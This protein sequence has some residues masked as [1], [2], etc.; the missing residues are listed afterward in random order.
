MKLR[1]IQGDYN[2]GLDLGTGSVGWAVTSIYGELLYFKSKPTWGSRIFPSA[3]TAAG[4]RSKRGQRRRYIRRRWRL[5]LLQEMFESEISGVDPNFFLR[6]NQARLLKEDRQKDCSDYHSPLFITKKDEKAY[7]RRFPSIYHLRAYLMSTEEKA[8]IREIYLALHH[9]VKYRGNF[10]YQDNPSLRAA[11]TSMTSSVEYFCDALEEWCGE[12]EMSCLCSVAEIVKALENGATKRRAKQEA[13]QGLL[14][15]DAADTK[16][17]GKQ[18]ANAIVGFKADFSKIFSGE[19]DGAKFAL[20]EDEPIEKYLAGLSDEDAALFESLR[21]VYSA[22]I[23]SGIIG[24]GD[25]APITSGALEHVTGSTLSFCKVREY[26][27]YKAD[28]KNLKDLVH[29]YASESYSG[30]FRGAYYEGTSIYDPAVA[31]GYT[32]YNAAHSSMQYAA[33]AKEVKNLL[34]GTGAEQDERYQKMMAAFEEERFLRRLRTSDNGSIPYQL[35]L[36]EMTAIIQNQGRHYPFLLDCQ[37]K[38]E[39]LITFRIPYYVGPLTQQNAAVDKHG[40]PRFAWSNR[41]PGK[42]S[43]AVYPWNWEE[44]ID[45]TGSA[46]RF[47]QRLTS[48]CTYLVGQPVLPKSSLLYEEFCVLNELNGARWSQDG[49]KWHRFNYN[50]RMDILEELFRERA[51]VTYT[52]VANWMRS[53]RGFTHVHVKG[54]QGETKFESSLKSYR[55]FCKD[56]FLVDELPES[57]LPMI[58]TIIL[59]STIFEDR[60][61]LKEELERKFGSELT[62]E[63]IKKIVKKRLTGWGRLSERLLTGVKA[64]TPDGKKS[65]MDIMRE[66]DPNSSRKNRTM[67]FMEILHD[68]ALEF[69]QRIEDENHDYLSEAGEFSIDDLP[70]S[71]ALRRTV[72]QA[73]RIIDE[74]IRIAGKPPVHIFIETTREDTPLDKKNRT[75]KRYEKVSGA[76][77]RFNAESKTELLK[78]LRACSYA[79]LNDERL[80]LYFIQGGKS[81]YSN[82]PLDINKLYGSDYQVDHIIPQAYIK[83]DS[84]ENKALVL[85]SENQAKTDE[86]LLPNSMRRKMAPYWQELHRAGLIGDKKFNNLMRSTMDERRIK[87]FIARQLVETSQIV[88]FVRMLLKSKLPDSKIVSIKAGISSDIRK[89]KRFIKC[90]EINDYHHAHDALLAAAVGRFV[91]NFYPGI[92]EDPIT[93]ARVVKSFV[94]KQAQELNTKK[95]VPGDASFIVWNFTQETKFDENTGEVFWDAEFECKRIRRYLSYRQVFLSRM[96]EENSGE[97]WDET[98]YSP[99]S[100]MKLALP[101]KS[102]LDPDKYGGFTSEKFAY[103]FC[104]YAINK[105]G[106]RL[107]DFAPVPVSKCA[108]GDFDIVEYAQA[109]AGQRG[110]SFDGIARSKISKKQLIEVNGARLFITGA[111]EARNANQFALDQSELKIA[112]KLFDDRKVCSDEEL[113]QLFSVLVEKFKAYD[114]E[115]YRILK[116]AERSVQFTGLEIAGKEEVLKNLIQL[117]AATVNK[118]DI[119]PIGGSKYSGAIQP[120]YQKLL[121]SK[122][123]TFIDQSVTGM[124]EKRTSIGL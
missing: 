114:V 98:I 33:F 65:I 86:L 89:Y 55:F 111:K 8:D 34:D 52:M 84:I 53:R 115:H 80:H 4:T 27:Q 91:M 76:I 73:C 123:V 108:G 5:G 85:S 62:P 12:R 79:D 39:S 15:L 28:L 94:R 11:D 120:D 30:F 3:A 61:I 77:S 13:V 44:V 102:Q 112:A 23:L 25:G 69:K 109:V 104:Y 56:V 36:E 105:K 18:L 100:K 70:G 96:P 92:I 74:I 21:R 87:G 64:E 2:I 20:A 97:F 43:A 16:T 124:F 19:T 17:V 47:I 22:F 59:W 6:L 24:S 106:E 45:K 107:I 41:L 14:G 29:G 26:E 42:E 116:L 75:K 81:L 9:M 103:F 71:P 63:Q 57:K 110:F 117:S 78:E 88:Q 49:D 54:G 46:H 72:N 10:L 37:D 32:K 95:H 90:R 122:P 58:E 7:Y 82:K 118:I 40:E 35:H 66:G 31:Q 93:Y 1:N 83:D 101:L 38:L 67:V 48:D 121:T 113:D 99:R 68:D 50:D 119:R 51:S 60:S